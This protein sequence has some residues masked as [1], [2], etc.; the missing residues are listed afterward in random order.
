[1]VL[2]FALLRAPEDD[3]RAWLVRKY[4]ADAIA[5]H[6]GGSKELTPQDRRRDRM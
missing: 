6:D 4:V 5:I 2:E 3:E 1:M